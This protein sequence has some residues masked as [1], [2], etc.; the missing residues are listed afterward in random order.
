MATAGALVGL[1]V[2]G[3]EVDDIGTTAKTLPQ[4][5]ELWRSLLGLDATGSPARHALGAVA[6]VSWLPPDSDEDDG[7]FA[8]WDESDAKVRPNPEGQP[9]AHQDP[10]RARRRR[11]GRVLSVDRGRYTVLVDDG[12]PDEHVLLGKR[13]RELRDQA[14]VTGDVVDIV[15]DTSGDEGTLG[16]I[17][18]IRPRETVLRRSADD[19]DTVERVVV[20][21]ADQLLIVVATAEP[22]TAARGSSTATS[23]RPTTRASPR[24]WS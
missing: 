17:V 14:I 7:D 3:V 12:G 9:A 24:C 19:T 5:P 15:G 22:G 2:E 23:S 1:V 4:F 20:A 18:R 8:G 10:P 16:R 21:N 13:A 11:R 6:A